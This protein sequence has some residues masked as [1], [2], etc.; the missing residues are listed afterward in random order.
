MSSLLALRALQCDDP[1]DALAM[2][3]ESGIATLESTLGDYVIER[4][5]V[6]GDVNLLRETLWPLAI[7]G[8]AVGEQLAALST[9][10]A[11]R[12][13]LEQEQQRLRALGES[14]ADWPRQLDLEIRKL[15]LERSEEVSLGLVEVR[16]RYEDR[17][18]DPSKADRESLPGELVADLT[19]LAGR[20]NEE[21]ANRLIRLVE[22][23]L[24]DIDSANELR[25]SIRS[26]TAG[27]LEEQLS[28]ITMGSYSLNHY[29]RLSIM[30]SFSSGRSLSTLMTGSG[31]GLTAGTLI[32]PPIGIAIGLGLG[33]F[34]AY[35]AFKGKG[36]ALF[37]GEFRN[38]MTEQCNQTQVTVNTTFQREIIDLQEEMRSAVRDALAERERQ[39]SASL[40]ESKR[41]LD[42]E[43]GRKNAAKQDLQAR[44]QA[45]RAVQREIGAMLKSLAGPS[46]D[47]E[48]PLGAEA[49]MPVSGSVDGA[50]PTVGA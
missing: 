6:L 12:T 14:R 7:A 43:E 16:R 3:D 11:S 40:A 38:W 4:A 8:R 22:G 9:G 46:D 41:L 50:G 32:A 15:T 30:S 35:Q 26:F 5:A 28:S 21:A 33:A 24:D 44:S 20:L 47:A 29:D 27:H 49:T 23:V 42:A 18:K 25:D 31:L 48:A 10:G 17:L 45:V 2:R 37:Q 19:A 34:Y 39:I 13:G 1:D 36:R